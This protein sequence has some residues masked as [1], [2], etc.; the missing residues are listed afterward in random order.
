MIGLRDDVF[1]LARAGVETLAG[2]WKWRFVWRVDG[3]WRTMTPS[4]RGLRS[5]GVPI[6]FFEKWRR[7][8]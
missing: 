2:G 4:A 7:R 5:P 8:R 1:C 6:V 3:G